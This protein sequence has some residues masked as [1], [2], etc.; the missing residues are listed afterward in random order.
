MST[1]RAFLM[2]TAAS[3]LVAA[4]APAALSQDV[5]K[6]TKKT[7]S[8]ARPNSSRTPARLK[9]G[10]ARLAIVGTGQ[11]SHRYLKQASARAKF[12]ATCART[13][14][15]AKAR[16]VQ[17]NIEK[18][19]DSYERMYDEVTPDAVIVATPTAVHAPVTIAALKHGIHVLCEKPMATRL[20]D[21]YAMVDA[22]A[23]SGAVF[24]NMPYDATAAFRT[25]LSYLNEDTL[26]VFTGAEAQLLLPGPSR[27]NWFYDRAIA[28]G[29]A[30]LDTLVYPV[31]ILISMLGPARR[32]TGFVNTLIPHR[33]LGDGETMDL[34]PPPRTDLDR[35]LQGCHA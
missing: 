24:L 30:G 23:R 11:I 12:V 28:G 35:R 7:R 20:E 19:F 22:A 26:G 32:V 5:N 15:S 1:R 17:Y 2:Q 9:D 29:G 6:T 4:T 16:A 10:V 3:T 27:D 33:I 13:L 31:S 18:W 8:A 34:G 25:A 21:C 14:D